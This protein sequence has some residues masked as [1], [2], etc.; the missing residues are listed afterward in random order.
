MVANPNVSAAFEAQKPGSL[1]LLPGVLRRF[2]RPVEVILQAYCQGSSTNLFERIARQIRD[3]DRVVEKPRAAN[4]DWK[5]GITDQLRA[6]SLSEACART[7]GGVPR[8]KRESRA[9]QV[10]GPRGGPGRIRRPLHGSGAA[11]A[12]CR[13]PHIRWARTS[14]RQF[15]CR[16]PRGRTRGGSRRS[17]PS[18]SARKRGG[19]L[20]RR[21]ATPSGWLGAYWLHVAVPRGRGGSYAYRKA[22][23]QSG[24]HRQRRRNE[25]WSATARSKYAP[26]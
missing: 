21:F 25:I 15:D 23:T 18:P 12:R 14:F 24:P 20:P 2:V 17:R 10:P 5:N 3:D 8:M 7:K 4:A 16:W 13:P 1:N 19:Q 11:Q 6:R 22:E 9:T 26:V